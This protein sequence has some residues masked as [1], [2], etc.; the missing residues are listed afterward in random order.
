MNQAETDGLV[1][2][3][4]V[5]DA[6]EPPRRSL[7]DIVRLRW[8]CALVL[9]MAELVAFTCLASVTLMVFAGASPTVSGCG[10]EVFTKSTICEELSVRRNLTGCV[11]KLDYQFKSLQV[12]FDYICDD[13]KKVKNTI[14]V[15]MFGVLLGAAFFGQLSDLFGRR[16]ALF[17]SSVGNAVFNVVASRSPDLLYFTI[18]RTL[19]GFFTGGLIVVQLV[20][21]VENVPR[22]HRMWIQNAITWS[23]NQ[24][25]Y[26]IVAYYAHD[27]RNLSIA[28]GVASVLAAA[29]ILLLEESPRWSI[30][31][32]RLEAARRS[33][34]RIAKL[35]GIAKDVFDAE[36][37]EILLN[38]QEKLDEMQGKRKNYTFVHLFCTWTMMGRTLTFIVG[39]ICTTMIVYALTY[40][41]EKLS[42]SL[43]WNMALIGVS[44]W[45]VN[46]AVSLLDYHVESFG[47]RLSNHV[48]MVS[49]TAL[50]FAITAAVYNGIGG[51]IISVGAVLTLA[52]CSQLFIVKYMMVNELYPTAVRNLAVSAVSTASR[53]GSMFAPQLFYLADVAPWAPY[54]VLSVLAAVD[55]VSFTVCIPESK[56]KHLENHLP[57]KHERIFGNK[58]P[59]QSKK[60]KISRTLKCPLAH[61]R[62]ITCLWHDARPL[63]LAIQGVLTPA[64]TSSSPSSEVVSSTG[65]RDSL[66]GMNSLINAFGYFGPGNVKEAVATE[67]RNKNDVLSSRKNTIGST[68][69]LFYSDDPFM[70]SRGS[71]QYLYDEQGNK[72]IDCISNV[73]HVGH[74]HP[75]V[76]KAIS[77]QLATST[78]NVRFVSPL[79][80]DCAEQLLATLP[81]LDTVLFCNS[82][83]EANDLALRLARDY[84]GHTDAIVIE[85]AYHGHVTTTMEMSPYKFDHGSSLKQ[86]E[87]VHVAPCPDVYRGKYRLTDAEIKDEGKLLEAG[88]KYS[89]DVE[90]IIKKAENNGRTV[91]A[92]FAEALQSCGG[93]VIP[94]AKYFQDV[95]KY[96]RQHGGV[97]VIDEVQTGFG[98]IGSKYWAHQ[99]HD[100]GFVPDIVTM[101]KP[102][103]NGFPVSAVVTKRKIADALGGKVGYFNTY[104][105]NP[106][107]CAAV[108]SV[109]KVIK[110]E[111]LLDHSE[112]MGQKL[113]VALKKLQETHPSIGD[114]RGVGLF[115]GIDL[116][117]DRETREPDQKL[118][119]AVI[120]ELRRN[121][122]VLLNADGPHTNI[123][124]IKPPLCFDQNNIDEVVN[125]LDQVLTIMRR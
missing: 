123:L 52:M 86:P 92:Y 75:A 71:M 61:Q 72:F 97:I 113:G 82:G 55:L 54:A 99:L 109:M 122:G 14:S 62:R 45:I 6:T 66:I 30:Q 3:P 111:N 64:P 40:N 120:L 39:I 94:P 103:G 24:I 117:K 34:Q 87:W 53:V 59:L 100:D 37:D 89:K 12:E 57:P 44:R 67:P 90:N 121:Y 11:P 50:L 83:S 93:Q 69:Q 115:W 9:L 36:I 116:V 80:T 104:G 19:A 108:M 42:G 47:R 49:T 18:W 41:M 118:A 25:I 29:V 96:V 60:G 112:A 88:E 17:F 110:D 4:S 22:R 32:G 51:Y 23:P 31:K 43:Y 106:V 46:I 98:R 74:C 73:Q 105:G 79:L 21:M 10:N 13:A 77:H 65:W 8:Y 7:D 114:I 102:M 84:T 33:L 78:C 2:V 56:G 28:V 5:V 95:A 63:V 20:F 124:K 91:A 81:H 119:L 16:K 68:C 48:A 76:V 70:V 107:A 101:G 15:Q 1:T 35:D 125:A 26:P 58:T 27:W 85:H 38:E